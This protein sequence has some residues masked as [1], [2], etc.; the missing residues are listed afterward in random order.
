MNIISENNND[1]DLTNILLDANHVHN[2]NTHTVTKFRP[3]DLINILNPNLIPLI[4]Y[5]H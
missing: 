4:F 5:N 3:I 2:F 1:I